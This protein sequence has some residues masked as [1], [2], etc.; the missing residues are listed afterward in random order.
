VIAIAAHAGGGQPEHVAG[1]LIGLFS[2][3]L[4]INHHPLQSSRFDPYHGDQG[5]EPYQELIDYVRQLNGLIFWAHPE[6]NYSKKDVQLG[7]I[8]MVT[9][10][11]PEDLIS[12]KNYTG[13]SAIYGDT[14]TKTKPGKH[15]DQILNEYCMGQ[16]VRPIWGIAGADFHTKK[17]GVELDTFQ[18]VFMAK[19]KTT[20]A[21]LEA[22]ESGKVYAVQKK[23]NY[24]MSFDRFE[25]IDQR[26]GNRAGMG[27]EMDA[28]GPPIIEGRVSAS[29]G[30]AYLVK[31]VLIRAGKVWKSFD[32]KTPLEFHFVERD[33]WKG[34]IFYRLEVR[35]PDSQWLLSNPIF[36]SRQ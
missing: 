13:F 21:V 34:K 28:T 29:D 25:A 3:A 17:K 10:H 27:D 24:R 30:K 22:L 9:K 14:I 8:K 26:T 20:A 7:P 5:I 23:G 33:R 31:V 19:E 11:Y 1:V 18:T 2:V 16:R 32:G 12:S 4:L 15:W 6:S 35:G 36:I